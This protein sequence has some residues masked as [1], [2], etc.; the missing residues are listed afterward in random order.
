MATTYTASGAKAA[1]QT[2]LPKEVFAV[3]VQNHQLLKEAYLTY[4]ANG[5][6]A[7]AKTKTRGEVSGG[8]KKPWR[9]KGTGRARFGS[10]RVPIWRGGGITF[11]PTGE[12]NYTRK[13]NLKAKRTALKQALSLKSD[14]IVVIESF[15]PKDAKTKAAAELLSKL[16]A[17]RRT[18]VIVENKNDDCMRATRNLQN[19]LV[20]QAQY[21]NVYDVMN[22]DTIV[23]EK[24][25]IDVITAWLG[26]NK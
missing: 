15:A 3:E 24:P 5:R 12:Q 26:G 16:G 17:V 6:S 1:S 18:L 20:V 9:Q 25:A 13:L 22:A 8:G 11:G 10:S 21:T 14:K 19:V 4:L 2:T 7:T 23:I